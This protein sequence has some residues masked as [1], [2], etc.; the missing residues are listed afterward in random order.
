MVKH[1]GGRV[2]VWTVLAAVGWLGAGC[3]ERDSPIER[4][5]AGQ[6]SKRIEIAL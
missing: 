6:Q 4:L 2:G 5:A 1:R 3:F